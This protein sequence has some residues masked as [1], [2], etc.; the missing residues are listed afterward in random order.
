MERLPTN[1]LRVTHWARSA[2]PQDSHGSIGNLSEIGETL[3]IVRGPKYNPLAHLPNT[4]ISHCIKGTLIT[5]HNS[6]VIGTVIKATR[7]V[8]RTH[9]LVTHSNRQVWYRT[10]TRGNGRDPRGFLTLSFPFRASSRQ[11]WLSHVLH[12]IHSLIIF[13]PQ[14]PK[15]VYQNFKT[16]Q[17]SQDR[18]QVVGFLYISTTSSSHT[19]DKC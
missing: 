5:P 8:N 18:E 14:S 7:L 11:H 3:L 2:L 6:S 17:S 1:P 12:N 15:C 9:V 10:N 13:L 4:P 19:S 16:E